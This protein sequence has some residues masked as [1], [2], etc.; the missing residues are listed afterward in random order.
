MKKKTLTTTL[1]LTLIISSA[2]SL[3]GCGA[4]EETTSSRRPHNNEV[5]TNTTSNEETNEQ[6]EQFDLNLE[7]MTVEFYEGR[8]ISTGEYLD[9]KRYKIELNDEQLKEAQ[10]ALSKAYRYPDEE[11]P[12]KV[13]DLI[14]SDDFII[15]INDSLEFYSDNWRY[16]VCETEDYVCDATEFTEYLSKLTDEYLDENEHITPLD[17]G[18]DFIVME[19]QEV[20]VTDNLVDELN[21]FN[22]TETDIDSTYEDYG[23]IQCV[24]ALKDNN[25]LL[26]YKDNS[27]TGYLDGEDYGY[28]VNI[29]GPTIQSMTDCIK[30]YADNN[31]NNLGAID[32]DS[33]VTFSYDGKEYD[34]DEDLT[35]EI[36]KLSSSLDYS[37]HDWLTKDYDMGDCV[38]VTLDNGKIC[39]P[40]D[41]SISL[42][43]YYIAD[44]GEIYLITDIDDN[45]IQKIFKAVGLSE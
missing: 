2:L 8:N 43:R 35:Y 30:L 24:I 14:I 11:N 10:E 34:A 16:L 23:E 3:T 26:L 20:E 7:S 17:C 4:E 40:V 9:A 44:N 6:D 18:I 15:T 25:V 45:I 29:N 42:N 5:T 37:Q 21:N 1:L 41:H 28:F 39:I 22:F 12:L 38:T 36:N 19:N 32:N 33:P 27:H 31:E 13:C